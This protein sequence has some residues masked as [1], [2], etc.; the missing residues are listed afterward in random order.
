MLLTQLA[1]MAALA[2]AVSIDSFGVGIAYGL[3]KITIPIHSMIIISLCSGAVIWLSMQAGGWLSQYLSITIAGRIG[4]SILIAIGVWALYQFARG[5][6]E[7]RA[8]KNSKLDEV[9]AA[10]PKRKSNATE[11]SEKKDARNSIEMKLHQVASGSQPTNVFTIELKTLGIVI[12]ILRKPQTADF[13]ASG[14]ISASE[15]FMLGIALS[16]DAFGAGIAAGLMGLHMIHTPLLIVFCSAFFL[17]GGTCIGRKLAHYRYTQFV[18]GLP[19]LLL[20][21]LGIIKLF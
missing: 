21:I 8:E 15:A 13:D 9:Q 17:I 1:S 4:A 18:S 19:G 16:L 5:V 11:T 10:E 20:I 3:R 14:T 6:H 2:I 7:Q 12:Q